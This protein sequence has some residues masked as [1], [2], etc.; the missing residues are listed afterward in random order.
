MAQE[1]LNEANTTYFSE[2]NPDRYN[3]K[4]GENIKATTKEL[5]TRNLNRNITSLFDLEFSKK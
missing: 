4:Y 5:H 1:K 2:R 3:A